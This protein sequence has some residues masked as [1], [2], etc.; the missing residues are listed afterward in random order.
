MKPCKCVLA[1]F[2]TTWGEIMYYGYHRVS[3]K[4]QHL[5]RGVEGIKAF[6]KERNYPLE[7]MYVDKVTGKS[8][9]RPRYIV[10]KEDVLRRGDTLIFYEL[11]R[12]GRNKAEIAAELLYFKNNDVRVMFL[13]I[14][15][16]TIVYNDFSDDL[17][18]VIMETINN[19]LIEVCALNAQTEI[20]RKQK[21]CD[22][23]RAA[24]KAR[25]EWEKYGR[26]RK[27]NIAD[28][29]QQ[30]ARVLCGEIGSLALMRE[31]GLKKD[32]YFRYVREIREIKGRN[33]K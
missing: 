18:R 14:P 24:M 10:L 19:I 9:D 13:D 7:K 30:Y 3:T 17:S 26:P 1:S 21:R 29:S 15:T 8:F 23:G 16:T 31:L 32:T 20:E 5:D 2:A 6:C 25:G 28:F 12:A 22:E 4:E 33:K 11:D 27:M